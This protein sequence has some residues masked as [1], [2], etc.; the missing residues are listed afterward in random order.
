MGRMIGF[1]PPPGLRLVCSSVCDTFLSSWHHSRFLSKYQ[2]RHCLLQ[3]AFLMVPQLGQGPPPGP[4][5]SLCHLNC[6][7]GCEF[8]EGMV[9]PGSC[10][11]NGGAQ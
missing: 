4:Y 3:E 9:G 10:Q 6:L 1:V 7:L 2:L 11:C 8:P 5:N